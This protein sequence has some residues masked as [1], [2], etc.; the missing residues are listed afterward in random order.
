GNQKLNNTATL[1]GTGLPALTDTGDYLCQT[2]S[3]AIVKTPDGRTFNVGDQIFFDIVVT[4]NGP[5][6]AQNVVVSDV[7]PTPG[8]LNSW[9][10]TSVTPSGSITPPVT[11]AACSITG[12][13]TLACNLGS[14]SAGSSV[15]IRVTT[16]V[17]GG[18]IATTCPSNG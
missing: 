10:V 5:A 15:A 13:K 14:M 12:G 7:L 3:I 16:N 11:A 4:S 8:N 2:P 17:T 1:T 6:T 9:V 18:A